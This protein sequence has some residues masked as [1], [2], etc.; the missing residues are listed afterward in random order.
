MVLS[1]I[2]QKQF[3]CRECEGRKITWLEASS[4]ALFDAIYFSLKYGFLFVVV[5]L[6]FSYVGVEFYSEL[7]LEKLPEYCAMI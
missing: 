4:G 5:W 1:P 2:E 3:G 7:F 6:F